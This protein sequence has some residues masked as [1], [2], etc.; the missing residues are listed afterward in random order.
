MKVTDDNERDAIEKMERATSAA[1]KKLVTTF[2]ASRNR[3]PD[4]L[5]VT[6]VTGIR[7]ATHLNFQ[8]IGT[9][10]QPFLIWAMSRGANIYVTI[11]A[12]GV[13][14]VIVQQRLFSVTESE[15]RRT[16]SPM[17][18]RRTLDAKHPP[19]RIT[20]AVVGVFNDASLV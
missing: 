6:F 8:I 16:N 5:Q 20:V 4:Q 7:L 1:V 2:L 19:V 13:E 15:G 12:P 9:G 17:A 10:F 14:E 11:A 3:P 18:V